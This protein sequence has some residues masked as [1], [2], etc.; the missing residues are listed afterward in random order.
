MTDRWPAAGR[1]LEGAQGGPCFAL[2]TMPRT[3]GFTEG[4][5]TVI[6]LFKNAQEILKVPSGEVIFT[7]GDQEGARMYGI[8]RR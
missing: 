7:E 4:A 8:R 1:R 3:I 5:M 2:L 6:G